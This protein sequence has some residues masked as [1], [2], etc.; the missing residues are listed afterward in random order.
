M[1]RIER[2]CLN[3]NNSFLADT[4]EVNRGRAKYCSISC[5]SRVTKDQQYKKICKH[6]GKEYEAASKQSSYCSV[7]CKSKNYRL[8]AKTESLSLQSIY[9]IL[10]RKSCEICKWSETIC[11]LHHII[12]VSEGGK[13]ELQNMIVVCPNHHRMIHK[14]LISKDNL[15]KIVKNRTI[16]SPLI[17]GLEAESGN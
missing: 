5:A 14:N 3:C 17:K 9:K 12:E 11:D 1:A 8:R 2:I 15:F 10:N 6:C 4:R 7:P 16:S 13:N